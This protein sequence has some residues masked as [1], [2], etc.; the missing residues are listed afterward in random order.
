MQKQDNKTRNYLPLEIPQAGNSYVSSFLP[1]SAIKL[2]EEQKYF[3]SIVV[4]YCKKGRRQM[5][6][7]C[8][9]YRLMPQI[10]HTKIPVRGKGNEKGRGCLFIAVLR[11]NMHK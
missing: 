6:S 11:E 7:L 10:L 3:Q 1:Q 5:I 2:L 4:F 8:E 9:F